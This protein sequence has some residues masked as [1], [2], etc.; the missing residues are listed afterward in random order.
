MRTVE[1]T[2]LKCSKVTHIGRVAYKGKSN[3][4]IVREALGFEGH[5]FH[6]N[7]EI[8]SRSAL[9]I[10]PCTKLKTVGCTGKREEKRLTA[11]RA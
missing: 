6:S 8:R 4:S 10:V 11:K 7:V 9:N 5:R 1:N 2:S 3:T